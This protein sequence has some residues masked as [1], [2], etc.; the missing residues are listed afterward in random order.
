VGRGAGEALHEEERA[1]KAAEQD[2]GGELFSLPVVGSVPVFPVARRGPARHSSGPGL[3][4]VNNSI[5]RHLTS[6]LRPL[7]GLGSG[8]GRLGLATFHSS[9]SAFAVLGRVG[10]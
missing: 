5:S 6:P 4:K 10:V 9:P 7:R 8:P 2:H 1:E 3:W